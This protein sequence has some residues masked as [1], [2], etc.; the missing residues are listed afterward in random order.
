MEYL[1]Y[2][3]GMPVDALE[4]DIRRAKDDALILSHNPVD[5][6]SR[7]SLETAFQFLA[8]RALKINCDLKEG[9][10]EDGVLDCARR[11]G[12]END[13][14]IFT[15]M[16]TK[17]IRRHPDC[18]VF[19]N[20]EELIPGFDQ[21][22]MDPEKAQRL[23]RLCREIGYTVVNMDYRLCDERFMSACGAAGLGLSL[24]TVDD[25]DMIRRFRTYGVVNITTNRVA[26]ALGIRQ[27]VLD[28]CIE[29]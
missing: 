3:A 21:S 19:I 10:L 7:L 12:V 4:I 22:P 13:R 29:S 8:D 20:A 15:G 24:W 25:P 18:H 26:D 16:A 28:K 23:I 27:K 5:D 9:G 11:C 2:T 6:P 17:C 1:R 14:I